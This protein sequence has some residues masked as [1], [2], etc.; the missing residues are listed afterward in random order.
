M[1]LVLD[2]GCNLSKSAVICRFDY[3]GDFHCLDLTKTGQKLEV[4]CLLPSWTRFPFPEF[5]LIQA[6]AIISLVVI[7]SRKLFCTFN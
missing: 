1:S 6:T 2:L 3:I 5:P 4:S 7:T